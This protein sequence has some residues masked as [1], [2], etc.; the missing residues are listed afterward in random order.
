MSIVRIAEL[1]GVSVATVSNVL[2]STGRVS[3]E[4]A[5]KV[6]RVAEEANF[7]IRRKR[8]N[9]SQ[10]KKRIAF[11]L[12]DQVL[13]FQQS[14]W[15]LGLMGSAQLVIEPCGYSLTV[16]PAATVDTIEKQ[17]RDAAAIILYGYDPAPE[18]II[19]A[20]GKPV[21]WIMR[22]DCNPADAVMEDNREMGKMV[23]EYFVARGHQHLGYIA[24]T[25]IEPVV[26]RGRYMTQYA[27]EQKCK[28]T[29]VGDDQLFTND[30]GRPGID[31]D[32]LDKLLDRLLKGDKRPTALFVPGDI[33]TVHVYASLQKRGIR[34]M[35]DIDIVSC[36][37]E[38]VYYERLDPRPPV[39]EIDIASIGKVA[40][41]TALWRLDNIGMPPTKVLLSPKLLIP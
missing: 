5:Q 13:S 9:G 40:A 41:Q 26:D 4:T 39:V 27:A 16:L 12:V 8:R 29:T 34:P 32:K 11:S 15:I 38:A 25:R 35:K 19:A 17:T 6:R 31:T 18:A 22:Y 7:Q 23:A 33:L 28:T 14:N 30:L 1:A 37:N 10:G 21:I 36:N 20:A 2:N 3:P 24:D